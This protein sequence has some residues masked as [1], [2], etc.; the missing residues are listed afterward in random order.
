MRG[1]AA[2]RAHIEIRNDELPHNASGFHRKATAVQ[3]VQGIAAYC[4]EAVRIHM[5]RM[6][7]ARPNR[8]HTDVCE[9]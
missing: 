4:N 3:G 8:R 9:G 5:A 1:A 2:G 7:G 6:V